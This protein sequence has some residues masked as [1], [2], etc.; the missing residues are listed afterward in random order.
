MPV[1]RDCQG[2]KMIGPMVRTRLATRSGPTQAETGRRGVQLGKSDANGGSGQAADAS[3]ERNTTVT[4]GLGF[5][6]GPST[7]LGF[8]QAGSQRVK[9]L[10]NPFGDVR[11][12]HERR[13][14]RHPK[15]EDL[16]RDRPLHHPFPSSIGLSVKNWPRCTVRL[17]FRAQSF[18]IR[19]T[20]TV[21]LDPQVAIHY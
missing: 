16:F 1:P 2:R 15:L 14:Y 5:A 18:A 10:P 21:R 8:V 3:H 20:H 6:R 9:A 7:T 13:L 17:C 19:T 11:V 12:P 4:G